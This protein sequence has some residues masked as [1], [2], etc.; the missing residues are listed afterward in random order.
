MHARAALLR[1]D[2]DDA[3]CGELVRATLA[4][5]VRDG[6]T[7]YDRAAEAIE[8]SCAK[9]AFILTLMGGDWRGARKM[10]VSFGAGDAARVALVAPWLVGRVATA[11][12]A[13]TVPVLRPLADLYVTRKIER[14]LAR[15]GKAAFTTDEATYAS[16]GR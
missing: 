3:T 16:R 15:Y 7:R 6:E 9:A 2:F 5:H 4:A 12:A 8:R 14:R 13:N 10:G 1:A 11:Q